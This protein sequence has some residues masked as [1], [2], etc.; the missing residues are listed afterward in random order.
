M[1]GDLS[2]THASVAKSRCAAFLIPWRYPNL[3]SLSG[4]DVFRWIL[5]LWMEVCK[6]AGVA[7]SGGTRRSAAGVAAEALR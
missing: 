7:H 5:A 4:V 6:V 1:L 3:D 2:K